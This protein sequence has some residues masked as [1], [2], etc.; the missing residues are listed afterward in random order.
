MRRIFDAG[1]NRIHVGMESGSDRVLKLVDKD[2][3][4]RA[5]DCRTEGKTGRHRAIPV[6]HAGPRGRVIP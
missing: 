2:R 6:L 4:E 1:L 3:Q 5:G